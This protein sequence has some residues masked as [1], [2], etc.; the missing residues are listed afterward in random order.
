MADE[1]TKTLTDKV[2]G[3]V[4]ITEVTHANRYALIV[5][6]NEFTPK[7]ITQGLPPANE[8]ARL[9]WINSLLASGINYIA[10]Q[11]D[12]VIGHSSLILDTKRND[13]EYLI[14][15]NQTL[16]N[17]GVGGLLTQAV[18]KKAMEMGLKSIWLTVEALNFRAIKLYKKMGF[19]FCD[20]GER[21]RTMLL[22]L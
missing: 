20:S 15:V 13:G 6:Y 9:N 18:I 8:R 7:A 3:Q 21:E 5:M 11:D 14:F 19:K 4:V 16:R 12:I 2:G 10:W 17:K 1:Y 22:E